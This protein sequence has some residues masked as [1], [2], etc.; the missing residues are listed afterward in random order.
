MD[1][2]ALLSELHKRR[3]RFLSFLRA[4]LGS[5]ADADDAFQQAI[6]RAGEHAEQLRDRERAVPWFYRILRR[7]IVNR[8]TARDRERDATQLLAAEVSEAG[9]EELATCACSL[10][11][12]QSVRAE[13]ADVLRRLDVLEEPLPDVAAS[14]GITVNNATVRLHRARKALRAELARVCGTESARQ[15]LDCD[16]AP[17]PDEQL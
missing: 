17:T 5:P 13:Y 9:E 8:W 2:D 10:G 4:R 16:C 7:E 6:L 1:R 12:L 14:L 15:C 3:P 11:L